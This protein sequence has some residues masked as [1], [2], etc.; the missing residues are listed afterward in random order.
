MAD[1]NSKCI[2]MVKKAAKKLEKKYGK[3]LEL[4]FYS[5]NDLKQKDPLIK[6]I[7]TNSVEIFYLL[8]NLLI[9]SSGFAFLKS[10][11]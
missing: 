6:E 4:H 2:S 9:S 11:L 8:R 7:R 3:I 5:E 1:E 10:T